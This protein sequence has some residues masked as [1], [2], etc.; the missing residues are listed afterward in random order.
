[1][2]KVEFLQEQFFQL[3]TQS[4]THLTG[5]QQPSET[6]STKIAVLEELTH[7]KKQLKEH[8]QLN[9]IKLKTAA[10]TRKNTRDGENFRNRRKENY[11]DW[12]LNFIKS[13]H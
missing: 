12:I 13:H 10:C 4:S 7:I 1:M 11:I 3:P 2:K 8:R 5:E 9:D 6:D